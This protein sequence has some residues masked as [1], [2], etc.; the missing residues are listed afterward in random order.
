ML[1]RFTPAAVS[2]VVLLTTYWMYALLAVPWIE[3][4]AER[5]AL[6]AGPVPNVEPSGLREGPLGALFL[7][8]SWELDNPK[9]LESSQA[10]LLLQEYQMLPDGRVRLTPFTM[11]F[12]AGG[13]EDAAG[14]RPIVLQAP[15]GAELEFDSPIDLRKGK[16]GKLVG[17]VLEGP[18]LI[19]SRESQPGA[20]DDLRI[21]TRDVRLAEGQVWTPHPVTFK[22]GKNYGSGS[23]MRIVLTPGDKEDARGSRMPS[24]GGFDS[25]ELSRDVRMHVE[26]DNLEFL[27]ADEMAADKTHGGPQAA[28]ANSTEAKAPLD[29]TCQ[30]PF[31]FDLRGFVATFEDRVDV[32]RKNAKGPSDQLSC[33]L[34]AIHFAPKDRNATTPD[35]GGP[36]PPLRPIRLVA[37]GDPVLVRSPSTGSRARCEQLIYDIDEKRLRLSGRKQVELNRRRSEVRAQSIDYR[38]GE[39]G[40]LGELVADGPGWIRA[41]LSDV[42]L[43]EDGKPDDSADPSL[44]TATWQGQLRIRPHEG[45]KLISLVGQPRLQLSAVGNMTANEIWLWVEEV[46]E[47]QETTTQRGRVRAKAPPQFKLTPRRLLARGAVHVES[48]E[49][50]ADTGE[51]VAWFHSEEDERATDGV[52]RLPPV[53]RPQGVASAGRSTP[54]Q[55]QRKYQCRAD[56]LRMDVVLIGRRSRLKGATLRGRVQLDETRLDHPQQPVLTVKGDLVEVLGADTPNT[57]VTIKGAPALVEAQQVTLTAGDESLGGSIELDQAANRMWIRGPGRMTLSQTTHPDTS[58]PR[59]VESLEVLWQEGLEFDG[60]TATYRKGVTI[61]TVQAILKRDPARTTPGASRRPRKL[62]RLFTDVATDRLV[63]TLRNKIDFGRSGGFGTDRSRRDVEVETIVCQDGFDLVNRTIEA[64]RQ[65][66]YDRFAAK[67]LWLNQRTGALKADGPG[68]L[69]STRLGGRSGIALGSKPRDGVERD[70]IE[71]DGSERDGSERN[72]R[73]EKKTGE[74]DGL[75]YLDVR[76]GRQLIGNL[77]D[78]EMRFVETVRC[79]H[80]PVTTWQSTIAED[81]VDIPGS[82]VVLLDCDQLA[83][84]ETPGLA[85]EG[86][87]V[88]LEAT[89]NVSIEGHNFAAWASRATYA[90]AKDLFVLEGTGRNDAVITRSNPQGGPMARSA[91]RKILYWP[92]AERLEVDD[93]RFL[94]LTHALK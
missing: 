17:G 69:R 33:E 57:T 4:M 86:A 54:S 25:F 40:R 81:A 93:G 21:E 47:Q 62:Q 20:D 85:N 56:S 58:K 91:A 73:G 72:G 87:S 41:D 66:S 2:F 22:F 35:G 15:E 31:R 92:T 29:I 8:D 6:I 26:L 51:L 38:R 49:L 5:P 76:F 90:E 42:M 18:I 7:E 78:R 14:R 1:S 19:Y 12:Y 94:D 9:I 68:R 83:V 71:R 64:G 46:P 3:P 89:G 67:N 44:F 32:V 80:G 55:P 84:A 79:I 52:E 88:E 43:D 82:R 65:V 36:L 11:I 60:Q 39:H 63:V 74:K 24:F 53:R 16:I 70:G 13:E 75:S 77:H 50:V 37:R 23:N 10:M 48:P 59:R 61:R 45:Q 28:Q 30:G 34:L 27:P